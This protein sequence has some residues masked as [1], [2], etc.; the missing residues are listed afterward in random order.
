MQR[1]FTHILIRSARPAR[2]RPRRNGNDP[3][4]E[5]AR[6]RARREGIAR[7][8]SSSARERAGPAERYRARSTTNERVRRRQTER[9]CVPFGS[10]KPTT[11]RYSATDVTGC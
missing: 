8:L 5:A 2:V 1:L 11:L 4:V 3:H 6:P 10:S 9:T 7:H